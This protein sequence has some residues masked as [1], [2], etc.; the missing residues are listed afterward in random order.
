MISQYLGLNT[1]SPDSH[2]A[3]QPATI[4]TGALIS[5]TQPAAASAPVAAASAPSQAAAMTAAAAQAAS[6]PVATTTAPASPQPAAATPAPAKPAAQTKPAAKVP[7]ATSTNS[8]LSNLPPLL[9]QRLEAARTM[10]AGLGKGGV[11]IQLYYTEDVRPARM[12]RF[13]IRARNLGVLDHIYVLPIKIK[14]KDGFRVLYGSY[15]DTAS[16]RDGIRHLPKR[17]QNAF[18]ATLY[19]SENSPASP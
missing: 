4:A 6:A 15:P 3:T 10:L 8:K 2:T 19:F 16:A 17:Y 9:T 7:A 14:G 13:L 18:A 1:A 5:A 11:S 12:E